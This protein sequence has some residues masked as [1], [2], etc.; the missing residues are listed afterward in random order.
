MDGSF[1]FPVGLKKPVISVGNL[2]DLR[3]LTMLG[4]LSIPIFFGGE[5][6]VYERYL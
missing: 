1:L 2:D 5:G 4:I 3:D 6:W